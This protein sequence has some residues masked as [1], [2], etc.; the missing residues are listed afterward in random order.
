MKKYGKC[1]NKVSL[2]IYLKVIF[3]FSLTPHP[4]DVGIIWNYW[5]FYYFTNILN[6]PLNIFFFPIWVMQFP[7]EVTWNFFP[8]AAEF[9]SLLGAFSILGVPAII[10]GISLSPIG[11]LYFIFVIAPIVL[12][13]GISAG[14]YFGI[15][16][17]NKNKN[18]DGSAKTS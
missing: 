12:L 18:Q 8:R 4:H 7:F 17:Y 10:I 6:I 1:I 3:S 15:T 13:G 2:Y 14:T 16:E 9:S 5:P 11:L